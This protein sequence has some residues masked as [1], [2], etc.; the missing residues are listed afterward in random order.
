LAVSSLFNDFLETL[1]PT[2]M[3]G[4]NKKAYSKDPSILEVRV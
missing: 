3:D 1:V 2:E 4:Y